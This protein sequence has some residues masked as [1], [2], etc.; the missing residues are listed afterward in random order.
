MRL[1]ERQL[2]EGGGVGVVDDGDRAGRTS[3]ASSAPSGTSRPAE[4][5]G[6]DDHAVGVDDAGA[7]DADAEQRPLGVG[8]QLAADPPDERRRRCG[9]CGPCGRRCGAATTLPARLTMA[10]TNCAGSERSRHR[11]WR[12]SA[13]MPTSVAGLPTPPAVLQP[14]LLDDAV[15]EQV[16]H[17]GATV[18]RVSPVELG[19]VGP[20]QRPVAVQRPQQQAAVRPSGVLRRRHRFVC[21]VDEQTPVKRAAPSEYLVPSEYA[22]RGPP[23]RRTRMDPAT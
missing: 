16:A 21:L 3:A 10:P 22:V 20:R 17:D 12:P 11:M 8:D 1:A 9:R 14:E 13:S 5:G 4:V 6:G 18:A 7:G 19:Q 15:V 23:S 2:G